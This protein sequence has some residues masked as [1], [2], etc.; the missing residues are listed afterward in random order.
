MS[1]IKTRNAPPRAGMLIESLRGLGYTTATAVADI[2]DNSISAGART[3]DVHVEWAGTDSWIRITD[4]GCGMDDAELEKAMQLGARDPRHTRRADDLGRFGMGL[5]TASFSQARALTVHSRRSGRAPACLRWDLDVL[6]GVAGGDWP[7][8]EGPRPGSEERLG[9][10]HADAPGTV[11]LWEDL[12]RIVTPGFTSDDLFEALE[13]LERHL[14][15]VFHRLIGTASGQIDLKLNG[16]RVKPWDPFLTGNL[17]KRL[18]SLEYSLLGAPEVRVQMHVLPHKDRFETS[19]EFEA[20]AGPDGWT[21]QQG[22]HIY[23]NRRLLAVSGWLRLGERGRQ[24]PRDE[25]HRLARIRLDIPNTMDS[26]WNIN[27]LKSTASPP[28]RLRPQL[29]RLA[30]EAREIARTVYA[31]RGRL[32]S[33]GAESKEGMPDIWEAIKRPSG[34]TAYRLSRKHDLYRSV[35]DRAGPLARDIEA[36]LRLVEA[37]VPVQRIWLDTAADD[38]PPVSILEDEADPALVEM[39]EA[40]FDALVQSRGLSET[41]ARERL[42]RTRPFDKRPD[43]IAGLGSK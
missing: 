26:E 25:A 33:D 27:V 18:E 8:I 12:D 43:L 7:M 30:R 14:A 15:M 23:R 39:M 34:A 17:S 36:L 2:I 19:A 21:S 10:G 28:V 24:W 37:T 1:N 22:F 6:E 29:L 31:F 9:I 11:V 38:E 3:V 16:K 41:E 5:K 32:V 40:M 13:T 42:S 4:D 35:M 20:A